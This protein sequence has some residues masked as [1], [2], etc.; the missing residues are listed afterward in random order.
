MYGCMAAPDQMV[1]VLAWLGCDVCA[2]GVGADVGADAVAAELCAIGA[3]KA[4]TVSTEPSFV[5][6]I[7]EVGC[8][9]M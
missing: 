6:S 4:V 9:A 2:G 1:K 5:V 7:D 8:W 3:C